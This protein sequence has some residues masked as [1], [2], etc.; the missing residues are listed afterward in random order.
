MEIL[1]RIQAGPRP[2]KIK[3]QIFILK[4]SKMSWDVVV[5]LALCRFLANLSTSMLGIWLKWSD[6]K[7]TVGNPQEAWEIRTDLSSHLHWDNVEN[8][9]QEVASIATQPPFPQILI[10]EGTGQTC[11]PSFCLFYSHANGMECFP[12]NYPP[13]RQSCQKKLTFWIYFIKLLIFKFMGVFK[14]KS[15]L[16]LIK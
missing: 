6:S 3:V 15:S 16:E 11:H 7:E 14:P 4:H 1:T 5:Y 12:P 9:I 10:S 8:Q 13:S 2:Q